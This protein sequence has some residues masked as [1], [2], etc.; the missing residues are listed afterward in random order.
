VPI[1]IFIWIFLDMSLSQMGQD[2]LT[3]IQRAALFPRSQSENS[4][5]NQCPPPF[6]I[7]LNDAQK[8]RLIPALRA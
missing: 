8:V 2:V 3:T 7:T 4:G 6:E 5:A 1:W